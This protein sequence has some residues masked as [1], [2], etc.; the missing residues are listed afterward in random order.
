MAL[1]V[2]R[3]LVWS[4]GAYNTVYLFF[5]LGWSL[6]VAVGIGIVVQLICTVLE[7]YIWLTLVRKQRINI[8]R[9]FIALVALSFDVLTNMSGIYLQVANIHTTSVGLMLIDFGIVRV[10]DAGNVGTFFVVG[11]SLLL[12]LVIAITPEVVAEG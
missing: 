11:V 2:V 6:N 9:M 3:Y 8:I 4:L 12:A 7:P 1:K 10:N 5:E